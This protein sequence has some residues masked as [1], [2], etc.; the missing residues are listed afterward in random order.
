MRNQIVLLKANLGST[1]VIMESDKNH[2]W[3]L[4]EG[5]KPA[6]WKRLSGRWRGAFGRLQSS[7]T[8]RGAISADMVRRANPGEKKKMRFLGDAAALRREVRGSDLRGRRELSQKK[9]GT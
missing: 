9:Q 6:T 8:G 7:G 4:F 1:R 3:L 2:F 5:E